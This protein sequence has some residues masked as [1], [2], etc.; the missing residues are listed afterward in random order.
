[1][2]TDIELCKKKEV[3]SGEKE[4]EGSLSEKLDTDILGNGDGSQSGKMIM[5]LIT[6]FSGFVPL[7]CYGLEE[8]KMK[9]YDWIDVKRDYDKAVALSVSLAPLFFYISTFPASVCLGVGALNWLSYKA[10]KYIGA[11][12]N[13]TEDNHEED[14][15]ETK[16]ICETQ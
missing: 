2:M 13:R 4:V 10:G 14:S 5:S 15:I 16:L 6:G 8:A 11:R 12:Y 1:M 7:F 9:D 3:E